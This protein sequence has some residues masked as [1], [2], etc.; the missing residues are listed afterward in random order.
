M[1][2]HH[3]G[4]YW[5]DVRVDYGGGVVRD[6]GRGGGNV[7]GVSGVRVAL[8][9]MGHSEGCGGVVRDDWCGGHVGVDSGCSD[10]WGGQRSGGESRGDNSLSFVDEDGRGILGLNAG[11]VGLDVGSEAGGVGHVVD[12]SDASVSISEPV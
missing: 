2:G 3:S 4:G 5:S 6:D 12:H 8:D 1:G 11:F 7:L 10:Y 9:G